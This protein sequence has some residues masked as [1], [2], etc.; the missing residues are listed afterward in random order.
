MR[1]KAAS[2]GGVQLLGLVG[3]SLDE[4]RECVHSFRLRGSQLHG[5]NTAARPAQQN[6]E[7][8]TAAHV[9]ISA[10]GKNMACLQTRSSEEMRS[11]FSFYFYLSPLP[12]TRV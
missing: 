8:C 12:W 4:F 7:S 2:L 6:P 11:R 5:K 9:G 3:A 10:K 1:S